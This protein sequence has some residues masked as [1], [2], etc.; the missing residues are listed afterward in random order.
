A[1]EG[2]GEPL[3]CG[4]AGER[5]HEKASK[6]RRP[7][8]EGEDRPVDLDLLGARRETGRK[9]HE[10]VAGEERDHEPER[11]PQ[12]G[13]ERALGEELAE[14]PAASG[15]ECRPQAELAPAVGEAGGAGGGPGCGRRG[16]AEGG[17][18]RAGEGAG[19]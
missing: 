1:G 2:R 11:A 19:A 6:D 16:G 14:E 8:R 3:E 9:L 17:R 13:E 4:E 7:E 15:T 12:E 18:G 10:R 5:P